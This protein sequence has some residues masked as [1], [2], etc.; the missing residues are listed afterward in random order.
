V[1]ER[2]YAFYLARGCSDGYDVEDWLRAEA[3]VAAALASDQAP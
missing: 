1:R 2:A 3:E